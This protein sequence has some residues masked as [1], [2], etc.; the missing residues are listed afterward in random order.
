MMPG[1][2]DDGVGEDPVDTADESPVDAADE[3][4]V[5]AADESPVPAATEAI[6]EDCLKL[7]INEAMTEAYIGKVAH[8]I[9]T[10]LKRF[11]K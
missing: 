9:R 11:E 6:L 8:A 2:G 3:S 4:P 1:A 7:P 10:V 5:D